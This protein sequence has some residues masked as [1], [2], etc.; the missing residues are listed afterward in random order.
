[1]AKLRRRYGSTDQEEKYQAEL[2]ALRRRKGQTLSELH[3][4]VRTLMSLNYPRD[5]MSELGEKMPK[6]AFVAA[7]DDR[8]LGLKLL[9]KE[10]QD[11]YQSAMDMHVELRRLCDVS[12]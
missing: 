11:R 12:A 7:L 5:G 3:Q 4:A 2:K 9:E 10:P 6:E 8:A 1:M